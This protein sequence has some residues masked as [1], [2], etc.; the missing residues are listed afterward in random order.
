MANGFSSDLMKSLKISTAGMQ[1]QNSRLVII[2]QNLANA[3][4]RPSEKGADP[5][6]RKLIT[7]KQMV[8]PATGSHV[9]KASDVKYDQTPFKKV[10]SPGDPTADAQGYVKES[11]VNP[12]MEL[13]D[14]REASRSHEANLRAYEKSLSMIQDTIAL[15]R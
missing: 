10:Y 13:A 3:N 14:L 7:F 2:S 8:D 9:V 6:R 11:N 12:L 15:L 1:A 4:T 5:Y